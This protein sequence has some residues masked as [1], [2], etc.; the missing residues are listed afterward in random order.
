MRMNM[1]RWIGL[2]VCIALIIPALALMQRLALPT[3]MSPAQ[4]TDAFFNEAGSGDT[5]TA[6]NG[7]AEMFRK[8]GSQEK[9]DALVQAKP[10]LFTSKRTFPTWNISGDNADAHGTL[11][12]ADGTIVPIHVTLLKENGV[13]K[14]S[15]FSTGTD[16][17]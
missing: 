7:T 2:V 11:T 8:V 16:A 9:F 1:K 15:G 10:Q 5:V 13:W 6:Y 3:E 4:V 12:L 17:K 14:V